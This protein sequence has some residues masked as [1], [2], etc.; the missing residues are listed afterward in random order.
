MTDPTA[1]S[2]AVQATDWPKVVVAGA[3]SRPGLVIVRALGRVGVP[4]V[5]V[6]TGS[7][8][9]GLKS[10]YAVE[11]HLVP[12]A[13]SDP[14]DFVAGVLDVAGRTG[15]ALIV[16][17]S[18]SALVALDA[19]R[20]QVDAVTQLAAAPS[21]AVRLSLDKRRMLPFAESLGLPVPRTARGGGKEA[22][23]EATRGFTF[24]LAVKPFGPGALLRAQTGKQIDLKVV[25]ADDREALER[26]LERWEGHAPSLIA[27]EYVQ[28]IGVGIEAVYD[29]GQPIAH[30]AYDRVREFPL[31]GGVATIRKS[32]AAPSE[33]VA[34]THRLAREMDWHGVLMSEWKRRDDG[35]YVF[36]ELNGRFSAGGAVTL[37]SGYNFPHAVTALF[38]DRPLPTFG[39]YRTGMI[40][41]WLIGDVL[42]IQDYAL[43][44][45]ERRP[46]SSSA[47]RLP[48]AGTV[49]ID[50]LKDFRP[51]VSLDEVERDDLRPVATWLRQL[52][53]QVV[54]STSQVGKAAI[55]P[56]V[57]PLLDRVRRR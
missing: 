38:L 1:Q 2:T 30:L 25:F 3:E 52:S 46:A 29:R 33:A 20:E 7:T 32:I 18:E 4:V 10:R 24:P 27:Q 6:G 42:A 34:M 14:Q 8:P 31:T 47:T 37:K 40:E 49:A 16:P 57:K 17:A 11:H 55:R 53:G 15:S 43:R 35:S 13:V 22:L 36:M 26:I 48:P 19:Q 51:G 41:R 21:E 54:R 44:R 28:G 45:L 50:F 5:A 56:L 9:L 12:S 23:L 39:G